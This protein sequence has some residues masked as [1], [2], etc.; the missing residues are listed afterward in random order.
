MQAQEWCRIMQQIQV[1][2]QQTEELYSSGKQQTKHRGRPFQ[3]A[4]GAWSVPTKACGY[5]EVAS[6]SLSLCKD[7]NLRC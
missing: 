3:S 4:Y 5:F 7:G 6:L 2:P 1:L